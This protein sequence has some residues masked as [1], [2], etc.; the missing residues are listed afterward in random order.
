M[1]SKYLSGFQTVA[2][3]HGTLYKIQG[4]LLLVEVIKDEEFKTKSG[5][6]LAT[7]DKRQVNGL[8]QDKP[9]FVRVLDV[10][11]GYFKDDTM[12]DVPLE[13][14]PGDILLVPATA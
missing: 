12:E 5:I 14:Q 6:I 13:T 1:S 8:V 2:K 10:G 11:P 7:S 4:N 9:T 3:E